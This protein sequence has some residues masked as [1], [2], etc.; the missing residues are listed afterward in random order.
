[1]ILSYIEGELSVLQVEKRY[2]EELKIKWKRLK[3]VLP[4]RTNESYS[5][6]IRRW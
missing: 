4:E 6:R 1:M 3:R 5:K 2:E